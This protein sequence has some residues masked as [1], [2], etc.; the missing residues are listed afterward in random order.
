MAFEELF[1]PE[2]NWFFQK[3]NKEEVVVS[4]KIRLARNL[5]EKKFP[6]HASANEQLEIIK[7]ITDTLKLCPEFEKLNLISL[8]DISSL[9]RQFLTEHQLISAEHAGSLGNR[10]VGFQSQEGISFLINEEDHLRLQ[11]FDTGLNLKKAFNRLLRIQNELE[12]KVVFAKDARWGYLTACPTNLGLGMKA[13][14]LVHLP[15]L[16]YTNRISQVLQS[17]AQVGLLIHGLQGETTQIAGSFFQISNQSSLGKRA[18]EILALVDR[19]AHQLVDVELQTQQTLLK[20][21]GIKIQDRICRAFG[22]LKNAKMLSME[23]ALDGISALRFGVSQKILNG[24]DL[25]KINTLLILMQ[26]AHLI[27]KQN[28]E[29]S[30][31]ELSIQRADLVRSYLKEVEVL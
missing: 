2:N 22:M 3:G 4:S 1:I 25:P 16:V 10:A 12:S 23:E 15:A 28:R 9:D 18:S 21:E 6:N 20:Q 5:N 30:E 11:I 31:D 8:Q 19:M 27:K 7:I 17:I 24:L 29:M 13:S 14:I 26:S